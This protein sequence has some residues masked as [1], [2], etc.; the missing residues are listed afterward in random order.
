MKHSVAFLFALGAA[1]TSGAPAWAA[2]GLLTPSALT[3][4]AQAQ[5]DV[6]FKTTA[7]SFV[8]AVTR[9]WAPRAADRFYNL[10]NHGFFTGAAFFRV[11]PGF[12]VQFGL[13][14]N[15]TVNKAWSNASIQD[16]PVTQ[17]NRAGY[18]SFASAGPNT[19]TTQLFVNL[20]DNARLDAMGFSPFG[21]VVSGMDV[22]R[23]IYA[24]Y[25]ESPDQSAIVAQGKGYLDKSFPKLD[26]IVSATVVPRAPAPHTTQ[27]PRPVPTHR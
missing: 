1:A 26:R 10:V 5:F 19:R 2:S 7:G 6:K 3:A 14:P 4:K 20:G 15:P 22:V 27:H 16:D 8:V 13:S 24:G 17:S 9:A 12:V 23:K 21:K 11:V 25:G 18:V